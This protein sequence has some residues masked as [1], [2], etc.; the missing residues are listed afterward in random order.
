MSL[1][2]KNTTAVR[3]SKGEPRGGIVAALQTPCDNQGRLL[4]TALTHNIERLKNA[5]I[6]GFMVLGSTGEFLKLDT[7]TRVQ[8]LETVANANAGDLPLIANCSADTVKE[9]A[10]LAKIAEG[11]GYNGISLMPQY[12]Y[13][14]S[15]EDMLEYFLSCASKYSLPTLLYN[16]PERTGTRIGESAVDGFAARAEMFGIKQSGG[17]VDYGK[18]LVEIGASRGFAV[19]AGADTRIPYIIGMG[20][21]GCIGGLTNIVPEYMVKLYRAAKLNEPCADF[22]EIERRMKIVGE[23]VDRA[24]FPINVAYGMAARG[25]ETGAPKMPISKATA[26]I[27]ESIVKDLRDNLERWGL[28]CENCAACAL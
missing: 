5:G 23:I 10:C 9:V 21:A 12:F 19:F 25:Y 26:A 6:G 2:N 15:Q 28:P 27:G 13:P 20:C 18:T 7:Q 1:Y 4:T 3:G 16:F 24:T 17:E 14:Q 22:A 8:V 11:L